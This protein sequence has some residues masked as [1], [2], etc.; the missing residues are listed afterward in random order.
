MAHHRICLLLAEPAVVILKMIRSDFV[1]SYFV[2]S[3]IVKTTS[4]TTPNRLHRPDS[5]QQAVPV[6]FIVLSKRLKHIRATLAV[7]IPVRPNT[8][9]EYRRRR[10]LVKAPVVDIE[11]HAWT[12]CAAQCLR[13]HPEQKTHTS[14]EVVSEPIFVFESK[15]CFFLNLAS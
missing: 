12:V 10:R 1:S 3:Y 11:A 2:L 9:K 5:T 15:I 8:H 7:P 6:G 4:K 14:K 13:I